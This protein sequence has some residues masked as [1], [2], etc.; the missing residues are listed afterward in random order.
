MREGLIQGVQE[1]IKIG[2]AKS[3]HNK[4]IIIA[5]NALSRIQS[6]YYR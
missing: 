2:E 3:G 5:K 1:D 6:S 4:A